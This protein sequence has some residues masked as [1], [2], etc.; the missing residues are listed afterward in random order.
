M[1]IDFFVIWDRQ[2]F[3]IPLTHFID[4]I[5]YLQRNPQ[6]GDP[7]PG[8]HRKVWKVR[9]FSRYFLPPHPS[10]PIGGRDG[11]RGSFQICLDRLFIN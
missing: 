3:N 2:C 9:A 7:I 4:R 1:Y 6:I 5:I 10:P 8:W 11:V